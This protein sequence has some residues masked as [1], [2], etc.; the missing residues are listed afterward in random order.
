MGD[1]ISMANSVVSRSP[2]LDYRL[3][4][5]AFSLDN[6][7][8]IRNA[9]TKYVLRQAKRNVLPASIVNDHKKVQF[10]G[11]ATQ[12]LKGSLKNFVLS[13]RDGK[14]TKLSG[15]LRADAL[16]DFIDD[17]FRSERPDP[18]RMWRI[19]SSEARAAPTDPRARA[20]VAQKK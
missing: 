10:G 2:F 1:R 18:A 8:K 13:L 20:A 15:L 14:D 7:L 11:P 4:E 6:S 17:F 9:E 16:S 12:W 19:V 3:V 5:F